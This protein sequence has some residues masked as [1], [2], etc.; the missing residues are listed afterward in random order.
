MGWENTV[1]KMVRLGAV[2]TD[3]DFSDIVDYLTDKFPPSPVQKIFVNM[4]TDKQIASVLEI[5]VDQA[6]AI[7][8]YREKVK[9]FKSIDDLKKVP[10]VDTKKIDA[11]A[12]NLV[13]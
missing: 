6:K 12:S 13:F 3:E 4:A 9:G 5:D 10:D 11:K 1:T 7:I 2:G 8:A